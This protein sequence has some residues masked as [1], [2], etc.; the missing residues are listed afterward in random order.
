MVHYVYDA[1]SAD[2]LQFPS[3]CYAHVHEYTKI[4]M[5]TREC[6]ENEVMVSIDGTP[7]IQGFD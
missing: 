7:Q 4:V 3:V 2:L 6:Y 5:I 1:H